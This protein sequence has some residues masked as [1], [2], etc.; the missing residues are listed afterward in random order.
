[1]FYCF[2]LFPTD[3]HEAILFIGL[4]N[5]YAG[6]NT[7]LNFCTSVCQNLTWVTKEYNTVEKGAFQCCQI[8]QALKNR[9]PS[10]PLLL[11]ANNNWPT[12]ITTL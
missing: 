10:V 6:T 7:G 2:K 11:D 8:N 9:L 5:P 3:T 12:L 1:M 4:N